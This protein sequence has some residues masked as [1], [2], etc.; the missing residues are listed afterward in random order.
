MG[1]LPVRHSK[2]KAE[3]RGAGKLATKSRIAKISTDNK[4]DVAVVVIPLQLDTSDAM[5]QVKSWGDS[6]HYSNSVD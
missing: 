6:S 3:K 1:V 2:K 5:Y 4:V